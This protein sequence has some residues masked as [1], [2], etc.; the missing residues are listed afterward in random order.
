MSRN[1][2]LTGQSIS[3]NT[4]DPTP[5]IAHWHTSEFDFKLPV[6]APDTWAPATLRSESPLVDASRNHVDDGQAAPSRKLRPD[7]ARS[8]ARSGGLAKVAVFLGSRAS[9]P[10]DG[11][12]SAAFASL[13]RAG[14]PRLYGPPRNCKGEFG[15]ASRF[16]CTLV[17]GLWRGNLGSR[18]LMESAHASPH[19]PDDLERAQRGLRLVACRSD[20][21]CHRLRFFLAT[22]GDLGAAWNRL[23][24]VLP[25]KSRDSLTAPRTVRRRGLCRGQL[26]GRLRHVIV[27]LAP[28][29]RP[30][31]ARVLVRQRR[32]RDVRPATRVYRHRPSC[33]GPHGSPLLATPNAPRE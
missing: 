6:P 8:S 1:G 9:V 33:V 29:Q 18:A 14:S 30:R 27:V 28:E 20:L 15:R 12:R 26:L 11:A 31:G 19:L 25:L 21:F 16:S 22:V 24:G 7:C 5:Q 10:A 17:S 2:S 13:P 4:I 3:E 32:R 23:G